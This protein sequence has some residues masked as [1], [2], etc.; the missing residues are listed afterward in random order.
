MK[1]EELMRFLGFSPEGTENFDVKVMHYGELFDIREIA[2]ADRK[3]ARRLGLKPGR[4][5]LVI[6]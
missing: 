3:S 1:Y 2:A 6:S 4:P 5:Y